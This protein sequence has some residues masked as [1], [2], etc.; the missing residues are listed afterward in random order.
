MQA[1]S[2]EKTPQESENGEETQNNMGTYNGI[3][4]LGG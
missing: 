1:Q 3:C 2:M 4:C